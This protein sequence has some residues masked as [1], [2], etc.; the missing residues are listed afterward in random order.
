MRTICEGELDL[1][2][3]HYLGSEL[4]AAEP[5]SSGRVVLDLREATFIDSSG[6]RA[7]LAAH[8]QLTSRGA[9]LQVV[10]PPPRVFNLFRITG[11]DAIIRC[12]D[13]PVQGKAA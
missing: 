11:V 7:I 2:S 12:V 9:T 10:K 8:E 5:S 3:I 13:P 1:A 6:L 4:Q